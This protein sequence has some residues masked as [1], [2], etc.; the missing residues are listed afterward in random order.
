MGDVHLPTLVS[1]D[2]EANTLTNPMFHQITDG[3][4][5]ITVDVA[6]GG[7]DVNL[8]TDVT[9][10]DGAALPGL[11]VMII[12]DDGTDSHFLQSASDGDLKITLDAE[13]VQISADQAANTS[14]NPIFVEVVTGGSGGNEVADYDQAVDVAAD[15][16]ANHDYT[17]T[18]T[19][20]L[21]MHVAVSS[22]ASAKFEIQTGPIAGLVSRMVA[23]Q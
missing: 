13:I 23:C 1:A 4:T 18:G 7:L 2:R 20:F 9:A 11:G 19:E 5:G 15:G 21:L 16:S 14:G 12:T 8:V 22:S 3:T 10:A 6:T 17:V